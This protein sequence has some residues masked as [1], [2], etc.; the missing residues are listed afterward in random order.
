MRQLRSEITELQKL[1]SIHTT[2][3]TKLLDGAV[4][5]SSH[6]LAPRPGIFVLLAALAGLSAAL[7]FVFIHHALRHAGKNAETSG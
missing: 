1:V 4:N 7:L 5:V 6:L 2:H 3:P